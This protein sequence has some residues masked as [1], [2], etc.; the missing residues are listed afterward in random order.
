MAKSTSSDHAVKELLSAAQNA[1][2]Q[3]EVANALLFYQSALSLDPSHGMANYWLGVLALKNSSFPEAVTFLETAAKKHP[4]Y[5]DFQ[6]DLGLAYLA[7]SQSDRADTCFEAARRNAPGYGQAQLNFAA[8]FEREER[9]NEAIEA[10]KRG[11]ILYPHD[12]SLLRKLADL[13]TRKRDWPAALQI[14]KHILE[15]EPNS[16]SSYF[17]FGQTC[18][19]ASEFGLAATAFE[20]TVELK[21]S[22]LNARLNLGLALQKAGRTE[23][24]LECFLRASALSPGSSEIHKGLGDLYREL[25]RW[26][27]AVAS[28]QVAVDLRPD[29]ADAWQN[30]GL[31]LECQFRLDE[32]LACHERVVQLRQ[33]DPTALRY[34]GM[35]CEDLGR[36]EDAHACYWKAHKLAP[37]DP[38]IHWQIFSLQASKGEFP[39]AWDEHEWRWQI[40]GRTSPER[41]F[42]QPVWTGDPL[43]GIT[44]LVHAEQGFGDTI[45]V[46]RYLPL[47]RNQGGK[48]LF[49][50]PPDLTSLLET[51]PGVESVFSQMKPEYAFDT[52]IPM[53]SLPRV[54]K[55]SLETIPAQIPYLRAPANAQISF[56]QTTGKN[57]KIGL[58][59]CGS[60]SQPNDRRPIP[61]EVL[62]PLLQ[63][64]G[65]DFFSLQKGDRGLSAQPDYGK[66]RV[67]DLSD[68]LTDFAHTAAAIE[69]LD[70][71]ITVDTAVAHLAGAL[72]K[73]VWLLLSFTPDWRWMI[74][75]EDSPWYPTM[76]LFRQ[77]NPGDWNGVLDKLRDALAGWT[78][79]WHWSAT[80]NSWLGRGLV[81]HQAGRLD[82]AKELYELV[83][84][85]DP[86]HCD[87]SRFMGVLFRQRG[88]LES[89][90]MWMEKA[91]SFQPSSA[92]V[93]H[94]LG[95]I[96]FELGRV[97]DAIGSYRQAID[98]QPEFPDAHYNLGNAYYVAK[99]SGDAK[100]AYRRAVEQQ[101]TMADAYYNLGLLAH[102]EG[103]IDVATKHYEMV[104]RL[105]STHTNALLNL[106]LALKDAT[107]IDEAEQ[108]FRRLLNNDS[109]HCRARINLASVLTSKGEP[110]AAEQLCLEVLSAEPDLSEAWLNLGVIRQ[111]LGKVPAAIESFERALEIKPDYA[112]ARY[113]LGIAQLLSG[114]FESGW[115]NYESRWLSSVPVFAERQFAM[116]LW[117]GEDL[118]G[119][120]LLIHTEQGFGDAIQ[121]V[122]YTVLAAQQGARVVLECPGPLA[123]LLATVDGVDQV[124]QLGQPHP[125]CDFHIPMMSL[126][127]RMDASIENV[128]NQVPYLKVP[129]G[130]VFRLPTASQPGIKVGLA[131]AGNPQHGADRARSIPFHEF[132]A[133]WSSPGVTFYSL[134]VGSAN[135]VLN[136]ERT[137]MPIINLEPQL[138]DFAITAAAIR[139]LDLVIC[140]DTAV[141]HLSGALGKTVWVLLP[142]APDWRWLMVRPTSP[143]YPSARL[144]RQPKNGDWSSVI[145]TV[146]QA[147]KAFG[148]GR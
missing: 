121:F 45:Q 6:L 126:P 23:A 86:E 84:E 136:Q 78:A 114:D 41:K 99:M 32:A 5:P 4:D 80:L 100:D 2:N 123:S 77:P 10:C 88:D 90:R 147:L 148:K 124:V 95:L 139:D 137:T 89:A 19:Q 71:L 76:R 15:L 135:Q 142:F 28:W 56:P 69:N 44:L 79:K 98:I 75:R 145:E 34:L 120:S 14:W 128:P 134:Q 118:Q 140:V 57:P 115:M 83:L 9:P 68:Q 25:E 94:D 81:H 52:H 13:H 113:N 127:L 60:L 58:V 64:A 66:E 96:R 82:Q 73:P 104:L 117:K 129:Q 43:D 74:D 26:P 122:R 46:A 12:L 131:W 106:G 70:L 21:P 38:E 87:A 144:F 63:M 72:G 3:G 108:C 51:V 92:Q 61:F 55:T 85:R 97:E 109:Q 67:G 33:N 116:P 146:V 37:N 103:K 31:G 47:I 42:A 29:Y 22:F 8:S 112:D 20:R 54:F 17:V 143:W 107:R 105:E 132:S 91:L 50:C 141:A 39:E 53:M 30:L 62:S 130:I 102:E 1:L 16:A 27:D 138:T 40:K 125:K 11:L 7:L 35:V 24:A 101:P 49:W 36:L 18:Y 59:W 111:A 65:I 119:R 110:E 48:V 93:H 133:L